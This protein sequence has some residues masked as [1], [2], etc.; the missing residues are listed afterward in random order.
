MNTGVSGGTI[1]HNRLLYAGLIA[2]LALHALVLVLLPGARPGAPGAGAPRVLTATITPRVALPEALPATPEARR[3]PEPQAVKPEIEPQR[4]SPRLILTGPSPSDSRAIAPPMAPEA[5][6]AA[7]TEASRGAPAPAAPAPRALE[8]QAPAVA[9]GQT[10]ARP[11]GDADIGTL[12]QYRLALIG[13]ARKYKR[14]PA[15][16]IEKGWQGRVEVRLIVGANG[17]MQSASIKSS[18]GYEILDNQALDML[19]KAKPLTPIPAALSG[20]EFIVDVPV[21]FDLQTG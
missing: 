21:I 9:T 6:L 20:R 2:S 4:E 11:A 19:K 17:M 12:D 13:V 3:R 8:P 15:Q 7:P 10:A 18:S 16:A 1:V 14:Y 5:V